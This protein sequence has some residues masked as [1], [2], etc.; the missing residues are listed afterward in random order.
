[1][2]A[3][4]EPILLNL[5]IKIAWVVCRGILALAVQGVVFWFESEQ[6]YT[7][8]AA[9]LRLAR[10]SLGGTPQSAMRCIE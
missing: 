3:S 7:E 1:L 6:F 2:Q 9:P 10:P 5:A 4:E 8:T